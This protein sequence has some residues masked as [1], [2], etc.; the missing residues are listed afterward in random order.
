MAIS[1]VHPFIVWHNVHQVAG[2][3]N[4]FLFGRLAIWIRASIVFILKK[5]AVELWHFSS[6]INLNLISN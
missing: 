5:V 1:W 6:E 2:S 3:K 4:Q